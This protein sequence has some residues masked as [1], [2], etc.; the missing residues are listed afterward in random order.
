MSTNTGVVPTNKGNKR[1][2]A[3]VSSIVAFATFL[4]CESGLIHVQP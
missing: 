2:L 1:S 4:L 3:I